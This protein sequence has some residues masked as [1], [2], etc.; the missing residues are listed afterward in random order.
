[1]P[2]TD[3]KCQISCLD[4]VIDAGPSDKGNVKVA[5]EKK[6]INMRMNGHDDMLEKYIRER[7]ED[8]V[9]RII[10]NIR[11]KLK[12]AGRFSYPG[13]GKLIFENPVVGKYGD[14][15]AQIRYQE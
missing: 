5:L 10:S 9:P 6:Q 11:A 2:D 1:V 7:M 8:Q 12:V 3:G 4:V 14:L 15:N 13:N